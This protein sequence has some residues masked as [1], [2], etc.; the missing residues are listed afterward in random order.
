MNPKTRMQYPAN[1]VVAMDSDM[2][3]SGISGSSPGTRTP[4][5]TGVDTA[6]QGVGVAAASKQREATAP[7][8]ASLEPDEMRARKDPAPAESTLD[9][10]VPVTTVEEPAQQGLEANPEDEHRDPLGGLTAD[11]GTV[12]MKTG[13]GGAALGRK[14][15]SALRQQMEIEME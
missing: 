11:L 6:E 2:S 8:A 5:L 1:G 10:A 14:S 4:V 15:Q 13:K 12:S 7:L 9:A 3:S